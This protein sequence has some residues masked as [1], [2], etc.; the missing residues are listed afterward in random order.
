MSK[1]SDFRA[2]NPEY[3]NMSDAEL[4]YRLY[5]KFYGDRPLMVYANDLGLDSK[6]K[7]DFLKYAGQQGDSISFNTKTNSQPSY[8]GAGMGAARSAFQGM[9]FGGGDEIVGGGVAAVKKLT[10]DGRP[11]GDIYRQEQQREKQRV[12]EFRKDYPKTSLMSELSGGLIVPLG[13]TKTIKGAM[14][15]GGTIGGIASFLNSDGT[16]T[17]RAL[18]MPLGAILGTLFGG[19]VAATGQA[20][21]GQLGAII[22]KKAQQAAAAGGKALDVLK[23]EAREA[24]N[25]AFQEGVSIKPEAFN[26]LLDNI[27]Q[28]VS[29]GREIKEKLTPQGAAVIEDMSKSLQGLVKEAGDIPEGGGLAN[30]VQNALQRADDN[31]GLSLDDLEYFRQ[32]AGV[33]AGNFNNQAE[34]RIG[35]IIKNEIDDFVT[36]LG[37]G[38]V[39]G[40]DPAVA[41]K[42]IEKARNTWSRMRKTEVIDKLLE[43]AGTYAGGKESGLRNQISNILRNDKKRAQFSKDEIELLM[44]IRQGS[45]LGNLI[46]NIAAAGY[47]VT[48]GRGNLGQGVASTTGPIAAL[49]GYELGGVGGAAAGILLDQTVKTGIKAVQELSMEQKVMLFR[50][51]VANG[52][53]KEVRK[54][55]PSAMRLLETAAKNAPRAVPAAIAGADAPLTEEIEI[56]MR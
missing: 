41:A 52:L 27:I 19:G 37:S 51:I 42:A 29:G 33:P 18:N 34:A 8:G 35:K 20:L 50:D 15:T 26:N 2:Q 23:K 54:K 17:E 44:Q 3:D 24:Y 16:L 39:Y 38:D 28:K 30:V 43:K 7:M 21:S 47:S 25:Q 45:P 13:A 36:K 4:S 49:I 6:Q 31:K 14:A 12:E 1:L 56:M 5:K 46:A 22:S 10:G 9:T 32:L 53:A 55:N 48:G 11:I 40:G